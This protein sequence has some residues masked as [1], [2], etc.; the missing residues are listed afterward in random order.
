[1]FVLPFEDALQKF[2]APEIVSGD[3]FVLAHP[4][5]DRG[6]GPNSGV[7]HARQPKDFESLHSGAPRENI[8]NAVIQD[9]AEGE[10][11]GDVWWRHHD[12]ERFLLRIRVRLKIMMIDPTLIP[13][14]F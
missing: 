14:R 9:V 12:G 7:I 11:A 6:L 5:F 10:D 3:A 4:F 8:L 2:L 13:F 1:M